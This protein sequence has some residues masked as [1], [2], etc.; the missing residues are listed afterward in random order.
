MSLGRVQGESIELLGKRVFPTPSNPHVAI[1]S[2][3]QEL[4]TLLETH[5]CRAELK[6]IGVSCGSPLD[7]RK[8]LI[9]APPNLPTWEHVD[10]VTPFQS[11]YGVRTALQNDAN[12]CALAEWK[13]GNGR[14]FQNVIFLTFG[15]GMGAGLI[16]DGR[17]Y[18]GAN[19]FAGEVGHM[20]LQET[21]P[22]GYGKAGSFEGFCSGGGI[23]LLG[24]QMAADWLDKGLVPGFCTT[25]EGL[26]DMTARSIGEAAAQGDPYAIQ[27]Y[28]TVGRKLGF[29][30]AILVD[31]LNPDR[32]VIGSIFGRQQAVLE[33]IVWEVL[34]SEALP[35]PLS[36]CSIV[37]AGLGEQVGDYASLSVALTATEMQG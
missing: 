30:L 14:G 24:R 37:P 13:W 6:G 26:D 33:P 23:A 25:R 31:L 27:V 21:G 4:E 9:L 36:V 8:G 12:A 2:F 35:Q 1:E 11:R 22:M 20:R 16:L 32:I 29:A 5:Q 28:E 7:S 3:I 10:I 15:T 18:T 19:D 34:R 17:L